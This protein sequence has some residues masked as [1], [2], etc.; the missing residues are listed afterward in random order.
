MTEVDLHDLAGPGLAPHHRPH[1]LREVPVDVAAH[2]GL[3]VLHVQPRQQLVDHQDAVALFEPSGD[4]LAVS[5]QRVCGA[6]LRLLPFVVPLSELPLA[7]QL[8]GIQPAFLLGQ[9]PHP[10]DH[11]AVL[12]G[13]ALDRL[14]RLVH[15]QSPHDLLQIHRRRPPRHL[16]PLTWFVGCPPEPSVVRGVVFSAERGVVL[17]AD[18]GVV[19][20]ADRGSL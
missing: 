20:D 13:L 12:A 19:F 3:R 4:P 15:P 1:R 11:A 6:A 10:A 16:T 8:R 7:G 17:N 18:R 14:D 9:F 5:I 2:G